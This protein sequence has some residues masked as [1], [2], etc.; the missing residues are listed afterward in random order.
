MDYKDYYQVMGVKRDAS[1]D[2]IRQA[3]RKLARKY[4]PDVNKA[5]DAEARFKELGE[6][7]AVLKDVEKRAAYDQLG[8]NWQAGQEFKPPPGWD[9]GFEFG[10]SG[11]DPADAASFSEFFES[12]FGQRAAGGPG[13]RARGGYS[14]RGEDHHARVLVNLE[15]A[16]TGATRTITLQS[17]ELD[18][19]GHVARKNRTLNVKIPKGVT[20]GQRIRLQGQGEPGPGGGSSGD[21]YLEIDFQPHRLYTHDGRDLY[22]KLPVTPWEAALGASIKVPTPSGSVDLKLP[23][24]SNNGKKLRLKGRGIP[25][26][27]AG[28]L[29][30]TVELTLPSANSERSKALYRKMQQDMDYNPRASLEE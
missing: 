7:Y 27:P 3:Y 15:D 13:R 28:D 9:A 18:Q 21:L 12:L 26:K 11:L 5:A 8:A 4:H 24:G 22:L 17:A 25:G 20:Q 16:F 10:G 23:P 1:Q 19:S 29:F 6:A 2:E 30:V 14:A